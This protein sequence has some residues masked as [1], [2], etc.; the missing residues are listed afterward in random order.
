MC[1]SWHVK[2]SVCGVFVNSCVFRGDVKF[3]VCV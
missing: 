3:L 1:V 2:T